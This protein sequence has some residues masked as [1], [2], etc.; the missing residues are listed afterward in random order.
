MPLQDNCQNNIHFIIGKALLIYL[1]P[2]FI[3]FHVVRN[4]A[5]FKWT[6][7]G[8]YSNH[9]KT[10]FK[11][12]FSAKSYNVDSIWPTLN[13]SEIFFLSLQLIGK[14]LCQNNTPYLWKRTVIILPRDPFEGYLVLFSFLYSL[15]YLCTSLDISTWFA[16][17]NWKCNLCT[18]S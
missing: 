1:L 4:V 16:N 10:I 18:R 2:Q 8:S 17:T 12:L 7:Y 15:R 14:G 9:L 13:L 5:F 6:L 3:F 11:K